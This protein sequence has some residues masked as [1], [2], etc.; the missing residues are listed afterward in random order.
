[1]TEPASKPIAVFRHEFMV[2]A[3]AIDENGH[4][5]NVVYVQ[6]MQDVAVEHATLN[7]GTA[8]ME[9]LKATWVARS[10]HIEYLRPAFAGDAI[11]AETWV[12]T[13]KRVKSERRYRFLRAT[14]NQ[15]LARGRTEW[16][17]IDSSTGKPRSIPPELTARFTIVD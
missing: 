14:D 15:L 2:D 11:V 10:H 7:G 5:N 8:I 12:A 17:F 6:W 1:M 16:V 3:R 13:L 4:V 9:A